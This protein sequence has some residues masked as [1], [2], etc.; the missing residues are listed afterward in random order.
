MER[1]RFGQPPLS[2]LPGSTF[3]IYCIG[4]DYE[5]GGVI[6]IQIDF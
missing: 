2:C 4:N 3:T 6:F 5:G 1:F